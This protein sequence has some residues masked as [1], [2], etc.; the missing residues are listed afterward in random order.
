MEPM[1]CWSLPRLNVIQDLWTFKFFVW[2]GTAA[3]TRRPRFA[4]GNG[5]VRLGCIFTALLTALMVSLSVF[6]IDVEEFPK[7]PQLFAE[8]AV[9]MDADTGQVL[10]GKAEHQRMYPASLTKI[11]T[12]LLAMEHGK[13][14]DIVTIREEATLGVADTTHIALTEGEQL[15]LEQLIYATMLESANDAA[16]AIGGHLS[17]SIEMFRDKMNAR[18]AELG[19]AGS[20]FVNANGLPDDNHYSTAYDLALI[21]RE[22]LKHPEFRKFAGTHQYI[23]PATNKNNSRTVTHK[24]YMFVLNNT[25]D[26]AFAGKTGWTEEAGKCL[27]TVA[28]RDGVTLICVVLKCAGQMDAEFSDSTALFDY[29]FNNFRRV[30]IPWSRFPSQQISYTGENG[31]A[32]Q[33]RLYPA[34][35]TARNMPVL[36]ASGVEESDLIPSTFL[37]EPLTEADLGRIRFELKLP[38]VAGEVQ[39]RLAGAY[40]VEVRPLDIPAEIGVEE[41]ARQPFPWMMMLKIALIALAVLLALGLLAFWLTG[42]LARMYYRSY[43]NTR[44]PQTSPESGDLYYLSHNELTERD[45]E[46]LRKLYQKE[47]R[48]FGASI[49]DMKTLLDAYQTARKQKQ[50][51]KRPPS[52]PTPPASEE[53]KPER[54]PE[55]PVVVVVP[56]QSPTTKKRPSRPPSRSNRPW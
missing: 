50:R 26:G 34:F 6:A 38:E 10:Y 46:E 43:F 16:S 14:N 12:C 5:V 19:A 23:I 52:G 30:S 37:P 41:P 13:Y 29:G 2:N 54:T 35:D 51:P 53:E 44:H 28:E 18:A 31:E 24:N 49:E 3:V 9:L 32:L 1:A 40:P 42:R 48:L 21:T 27:M 4:E 45:W 11:M 7:K 39:D 56:A 15:T 36:L 33:G 25:Y 20:H 8:A 55:K 22:A 17:G 47:F